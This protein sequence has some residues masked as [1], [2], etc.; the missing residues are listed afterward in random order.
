MTHDD[1]ERLL[2][3]RDELPIPLAFPLDQLSNRL[4]SDSTHTEGKDYEP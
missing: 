4:P 2:P 1:P 3:E